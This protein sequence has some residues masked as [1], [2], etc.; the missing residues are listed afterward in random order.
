MRSA[1]PLN[2]TDVVQL[3]LHERGRHRGRLRG[4]HRGPRVRRKNVD[5]TVLK[6]ADRVGGRAQ[7][8]RSAGGSAV[9]LGGITTVADWL[10]KIPHRKARA[11]LEV[12]INPSQPT[13]TRCPC[14][15]SPRWFG[16][17]AGSDRC[18]ES[19]AAHRSRCSPKAPGAR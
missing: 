18:S 8:V 17:R 2:A 14:T 15:R 9:D 16:L 3:S 5:V 10:T 1:Y 6:A 7:T 19:K 13:S 12:V 11:L 4:A